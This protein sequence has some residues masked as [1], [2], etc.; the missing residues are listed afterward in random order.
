[1]EENSKAIENEGN[2]INEEELAS[3]AGGDVGI[4]SHL[5]WFEPEIPIKHITRNNY[6]AVK[7]RSTCHN[8]NIG[9]CC[10]H[11]SILCEDRWHWVEKEKNSALP[12]KWWPMPK[13]EYGHNPIEP[14]DI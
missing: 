14:F 2:E 9:H 1:M 4:S 6:P 3:V 12:P 8:F 10:C 7:C 13:N 5:C 11:G